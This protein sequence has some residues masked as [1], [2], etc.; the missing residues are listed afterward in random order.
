MNTQAKPLVSVIM[1]VYNPEDEETLQQ[2]VYS[3]LNQSYENLEFII[4]NDGSDEEEARYINSLAQLDKRI[5]IAGKEENRGL[6][7]SLN[8]C[9]RL[10]KGKYI[11]RM[12]A[13]DQSHPKRIE[14]QV[15]FLEQNVA[16]AWCGTCTML[17]DEQD[18]WGV[19]KMPKEPKLQDFFRYSPFVHPSVMFRAKIFDANEGYLESEETL[20]CEDYEIFMRLYEN[21]LKG[22]NLQEN[23]FFYRENRESYSKRKFCFRINEAKVRYRNYKKMGKLFPL[24]WV[25]VLRPIV[26]GIMPNW[27]IAVIRRI[28]GQIGKHREDEQR[29]TASLTVQELSKYSEELSGILYSTSKLP[30]SVR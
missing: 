29:R 28:E 16:Y 14:K 9:I 20:R 17:F 26:A 3:I 4:W 19:R 24:G 18:V 21:G 10:A 8:E 15:D 6:A 23:L 5:V 13:D 27:M 1:G 12:D 7:Y 22:Y 30:E 25:Y 11:A 2:A